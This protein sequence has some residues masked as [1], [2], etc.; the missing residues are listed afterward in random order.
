MDLFTNK[1]RS[2][3]S[4]ATETSLMLLFMVT[5]KICVAFRARQTDAKLTKVFICLGNC[6]HYEK[7]N[8]LCEKVHSIEESIHTK[9]AFRLKCPSC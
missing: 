1:S 4:L 7:D 5:N 3:P 6:S 8:T 9:I 2:Y